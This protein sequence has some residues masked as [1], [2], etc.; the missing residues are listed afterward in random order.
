M[1]KKDVQGIDSVVLTYEDNEI[2]LDIEYGDYSADV[3]S[4]LQNYEGKKIQTTISGENVEIVSY[5]RNKPMSSPLHM[6]TREDKD[7]DDSILLYDKEK[8][9]VIGVN[10]P[11][12]NEV[13]SPEDRP[14]IS[15]E[16]S[17]KNLEEQETA[18][19]ILY[20]IKFKQK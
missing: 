15:F 11:H 14:A 9:Y 19:K 3:V 10:F 18:K 16:V 4:H 8:H 12:K 2:T 6:D 5:D 13:I 20:S 7:L 1:K 17:Y